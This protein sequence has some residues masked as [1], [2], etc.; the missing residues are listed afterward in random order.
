[1]RGWG[2]GGCFRFC[3]S[4]PVESAADLL[5]LTF[6]HIFM[7]PATFRSCCMALRILKTSNIFSEF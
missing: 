6:F 5:L 2:G 3:I 4:F 7:F 1:M